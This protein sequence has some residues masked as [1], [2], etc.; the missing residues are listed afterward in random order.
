MKWLNEYLIV[1]R[2][3]VTTDLVWLRLDVTTDRPATSDCYYWSWLRTTLTT[4]WIHV[5]QIIHHPYTSNTT[6]PIFPSKNKR[7]PVSLEP[8]W[9][10]HPLTLESRPSS[11]RLSQGKLY[12]THTHTFDFVARAERGFPFDRGKPTLTHIIS[13]RAS[14]SGGGGAAASYR[15]LGANVSTI[16]AFGTLRCLY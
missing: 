14:S 12:Y 9:S 16:L 11:C 1:T 7:K 15:V 6:T 4:L 2:H 13:R 5:S 8:L 3:S 10:I